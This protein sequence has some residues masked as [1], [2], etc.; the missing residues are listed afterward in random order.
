MCALD[1]GDKWTGVAITDA[2]QILARPYT[3]VPSATL[4]TFLHDFFK[5]E[6]IS[7]AIIGYPKTLRGTESNQTR[8][9]VLMQQQLAA[10]FPTITWLLWDERLTS[11]AA[12]KIQHKAEDKNKE[13]AIA[14][15]LIL[16]NYLQHLAFKKMMEEGEE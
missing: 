14:A 4:E 5:K 1:L 6:S 11:K 3:T 8:K 13:H 16:E 9:T 2:L 12:Q 15:A 10:Q 7:H